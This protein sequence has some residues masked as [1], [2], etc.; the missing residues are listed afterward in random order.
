MAQRRDDCG[1]RY[2][3]ARGQG[4]RPA[5]L[6]GQRAWIKL[7]VRN[8]AEALAGAVTGSLAAP[9]RLILGLLDPAD[10]LLVA[11]GTALDIGQQQVAPLLVPAGTEHLARRVACGFG[12]PRRIKVVLVEP[13]LVVEVAADSSFE[14]GRSRPSDSIRAAAT[15]PRA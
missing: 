13:E 8:T 4:T 1:R 10:G 2:R 7:R 6:A 12:A 15:R 14:Y 3:R 9:D 5:V 11:G